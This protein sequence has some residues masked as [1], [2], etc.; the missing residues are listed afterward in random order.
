MT[1][2]T[3]TLLKS[4]QNTCALPT[5]L[6]VTPGLKMICEQVIPRRKDKN[7]WMVVNEKSFLKKLKMKKKNEDEKNQLFF[8]RAEIVHFQYIGT[9]NLADFKYVCNQNFHICSG[10]KVTACQNRSKMAILVDFTPFLPTLASHN[11]WSKKDM[12]NPNTDLKLT[13]SKVFICKK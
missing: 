1:K 5:F 12:K 7:E 2:W 11:F 4:V 13:L 3:K 10:W 6:N 9:S 8:Y